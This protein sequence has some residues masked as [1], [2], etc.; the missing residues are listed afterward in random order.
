MNYQEMLDAVKELY[1]AHLRKRVPLAAYNANPLISG[2]TYLDVIYTDIMAL[3]Y[4]NGDIAKAVDDILP[5]NLAFFINPKNKTKK[6]TVAEVS[7]SARLYADEIHVFHQF[8]LETKGKDGE[9]ADSA[10]SKVRERLTSLL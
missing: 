1:I 6:M 9:N 7:E 4:N 10:I 3:G 2:H 8:H 5:M